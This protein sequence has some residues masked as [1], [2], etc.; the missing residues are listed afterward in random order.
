MGRSGV[1]RALPLLRASFGADSAASCSRA[2]SPQYKRVA[3]HRAVRNGHAA[4]AAAL[5]AAAPASVGEPNEN[6]WTPLIYAARWGH[7]ELAATLLQAGADPHARTRDGRSA[8]SCARD[9]GH[10]RVI[11]LLETAGA[12]TSGFSR[13]CTRVCGF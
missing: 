6:G 11:T 13:A 8:L 12:S 1:W 2:L 3:L 4:T 9:G 7:F 5:L 10:T